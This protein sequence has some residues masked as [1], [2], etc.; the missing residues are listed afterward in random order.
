M[1]IAVLAAGAAGPLA[2][3][4]YGYSFVVFFSL[5]TLFS[6]WLNVAPRRAA[7]RGA[8]FGAGY[9]GV[10]VTWI[11]ISI[12]GFGGVPLLLSL[13]LTGLLVAYLSV[14]PAL[15]GYFLARYFPCDKTG[16]AGRPVAAAIF[17][18]LV[19]PSA[20]TLSE[21]LRGW[22]FTGFP[23]LNV[24]Y[25][26]TDTPLGALAP[27]AGVYGVSWSVALAAALMVA[28]LTIRDVRVRILSAAFFM[29][30]WGGA[31]L[32]A[33][34]EWTSPIG[35]PLK[36]SLIQG[37]VSQDMKWLQEMRQPTIDLYTKLT[38]E[39]WDSGLIIWPETALPDFY[40]REEGFIDDLAAEAREHGSEMLV[41]VLYLDRDTR[42]Y[43]N[44]MVSVGKE[45]DFYH[46]RH[47]V[48]FTEYLPLKEVL[49]GIVDFMQVPM[50]DFSK[51]APD[52][53]D[54]IAAGQS[55]GI[56]I[57]FEDAFGEEVRQAL[58]EAT[59]LVNVSNDAWFGTS[60][61]PHQHLQMARMRALEMGR[62]ML[63]ATNTGVSAI[64]DDRG[65]ITER[66]PQF[67]VAVVTDT[68][69]P[70]QGATPYVAL[71]N[72]PI[73]FFVSILVFICYRWTKRG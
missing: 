30:L 3:A 47:L 72:T 46:K 49:G 66:G 52:E 6:A 16:D 55:I 13:F 63:R 56:S 53:H 5:A 54:L 22:I 64:I 44:S 11:H 61:A 67:D 26:Q 21:W 14:Y 24:G 41:G 36:V 37:N 18:L 68:V 38:R 1:D 33:R 65:R 70:R 57:C 73:V 31:L 27:V 35:D 59:L 42:K 58:P 28:L 12:H 48:P 29:L 43:Y 51:G 39:H 32:L 2:F 50:S 40:H 62:W 60:A 19:M 15:L 10:G 25:S 7:W 9:F 23:W 69:Q 20:W 71:G 4:P 17:I 34:V 45:R 8:L